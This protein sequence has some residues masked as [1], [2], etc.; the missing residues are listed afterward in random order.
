MLRSAASR[1]KIQWQQSTGSA[2]LFFCENKKTNTES[3]IW[4]MQTKNTLRQNPR[5]WVVRV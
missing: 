4:F 5:L 1:I 3:L 2:T